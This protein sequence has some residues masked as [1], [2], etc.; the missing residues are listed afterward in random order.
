MLTLT[1]A[2]AEIGIS[3][4]D[5]GDDVELSRNIRQ[6]VT[7][8]RRHTLRGVAWICDKVDSVD[9]KA[10]LRVIG[11]GLRTGQQIKIVGSGLSALD[12]AT[13]TVTVINADTL[14]LAVD[15]ALETCEFTIHPKIT[16]LITPIRSDRMWIPSRLT[17]LIEINKIEDLDS[18]TSWVEIDSDYWYTQPEDVRG[19]NTIEVLRTE[20]TFAVPITVRRGQFPL[21][22]RGVSKTVRL[23]VYGGADIV[24]EDVTMAGLSLICDLWERSGT[25]KDEGSYSFEDVQRSPMQGV[26]K[27]EALVGPM[28]VLNS[29]IARD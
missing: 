5:S 3:T 16:E 26:E 2:K 4:P 12:D 22:T 9:S 29:W 13:H 19:Y 10:R 8:I 21:R 14:E 23:T 18:N 15:G 7:K 11:H 17:P 24:P 27:H 20:G 1:Q 25:G 6:V 28:S